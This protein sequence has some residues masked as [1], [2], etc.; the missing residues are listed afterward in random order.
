MQRPP[1]MVGEIA[2]PLADDQEM[3]RVNRTT[4]SDV[5]Q[6]VGVGHIPIVD[7]SGWTSGKPP[8]VCTSTSAKTGQNKAR[9]KKG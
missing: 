9:L 4:F 8:K 2:E 5:A 1:R 3:A 6:W 7:V